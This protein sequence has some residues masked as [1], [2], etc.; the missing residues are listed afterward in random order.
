ML[1]REVNKFT[2]TKMCIIVIV[3]SLIRDQN[4]THVKWP[5]V[6][7]KNPPI[8][9]FPKLPQA[10]RETLL[11]RKSIIITPLYILNSFLSIS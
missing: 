7:A 1:P 3:V 4:W 8:V 11:F 9:E 10:T 6:A 5:S 2:L